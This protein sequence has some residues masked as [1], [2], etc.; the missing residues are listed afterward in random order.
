[1]T[2]I[3]STFATALAI[4]S[5]LPGLVFGQDEEPASPAAAL[6]L[7]TDVQKGSYAFGMNLG[8]S[9]GPAAGE[10]DLD[11]FFRAVRDMIEGKAPAMTEDEARKAFMSFQSSA[12]EAANKRSLDEGKAFLKANLEKD[13]AVV[14]LPSGLQYKVMKKGAGTSPKLGEKVKVHY[15]G[16]L[17][18]GTKFDSSRDRGEPAEFE[19]GMVI[20]GWNEALQLMKPGARWMLYIPS[21]LAYGERGMQRI[22][23]N[24]VLLF[25]VELIA[26]N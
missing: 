19:L 17:I 14:Q 9:L 7:V 24:S 23:P 2:H 20:P 10:L 18:D 12:I 21:N 25:D 1:M 16:T 15:T 11:V 8:R 6:P 5:F 26:V 13:D 22:P 3:F 4:L